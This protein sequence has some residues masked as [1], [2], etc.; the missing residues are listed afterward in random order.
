MSN[1]MSNDIFAI[2]NNQYF[3]ENNA[4]SAGKVK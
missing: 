2:N 4:V 3:V 1:D